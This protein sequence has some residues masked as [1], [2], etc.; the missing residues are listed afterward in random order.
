D[1]VFSGSGTM[2]VTV[3]VTNTGKMKGKESV[4]CFVKD[5]TASI[6]PEVKRLRAFDKI[7]LEAGETKTVSFKLSA[8][9][10]AFVNRD[11]TWITEPGKFTVSIAGLAKEF[12]YQ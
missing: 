11:M 4:L 8:D 5:H 3:T 6:T 10:L 2:E 1:T 7:E 12:S 9:D